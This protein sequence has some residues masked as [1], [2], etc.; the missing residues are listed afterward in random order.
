MDTGISIDSLIARL[1]SIQ[2]EAPGDRYSR[3]RLYD[4]TQAMAAELEDPIDSIYRIGFAP[5]QLAMAKLGSNL[6]LFEL[7]QTSRVPLKTDV[8]AE[9]TGVDFVLLRR[10][11]RY[12]ASV[13]MIEETETDTFGASKLTSNL[14]NP[15]AKASLGWFLDLCAP[16]L[17]KIPDF[18]AATNYHNPSDGLN[19]AFHMGHDT[20]EHPFAFIMKHPYHLENMNKWMSFQREGCNQWLDRFDFKAEVCHGGDVVPEEPLFVDIGGGIGHQCRLFQERL[21]DISGIGRIILQDQSH[22]LEQ[23]LPLPNAQ[24]MSYDFWTPQP[25]K[26]ARAYYMRG[27]L[28]DWGDAQCVEIIRQI[29]PAMSTNSVLLVDEMVLPEARAHWLATHMDLAMLGLA[30]AMERTKRHWESLLDAAGMRIL[31]IH[32]Y[33]KEFGD[34]IL[35]AVPKVI[36]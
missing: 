6:G 22:V 35:V 18:L 7:L 27:I 33:N 10:I 24:K 31:G 36:K 28:H 14:T 21:P 34:S 2:K 17:N 3:R 26:G 32:E 19:S 11:L 15:Q 5:L 12:L 16:A 20:T 13:G 1:R 4:A 29:I 25:V 23:A 9:K 30:A 8:L